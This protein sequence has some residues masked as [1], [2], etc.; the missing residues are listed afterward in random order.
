ME[1]NVPRE[2]WLYPDRGMKK[3]QGWIL[4]DHAAQLEHDFDVQPDA[5]PLPKQDFA[6]INRLLVHAFQNNLVILIQQDIITR[7]RFAPSIVGV[8]VGLDAGQL[9]L[10]DQDRQVHA[11]P[12][13]ELRH[14][15]LVNPIKWWAA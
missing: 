8:C 10:Q 13:A 11:Y 6:T 5:V 14:V 9:F 12:V 4:S 15:D 1:R 2:L 7:G 3:W